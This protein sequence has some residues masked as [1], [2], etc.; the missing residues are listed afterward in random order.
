MHFIFCCCSYSSLERQEQNIRDIKFHGNRKL[1]KLE[2]FVKT[3][4]NMTLQMTSNIIGKGE[5]LL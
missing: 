1:A 3:V 4:K 2:T 5:N